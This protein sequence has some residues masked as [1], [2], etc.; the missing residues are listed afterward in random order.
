MNLVC[1]E[2]E[3][4]P[5]GTL[6]YADVERGQFIRF[7]RDKSEWMA[8]N[9]RTRTSI[10][11]HHN[12]V[13]LEDRGEFVQMSG[14]GQH[15]YS[16]KAFIWDPSDLS[17][18]SEDLCESGVSAETIVRAADCRLLFDSLDENAVLQKCRALI[19]L[20]KTGTANSVFT[21]FTAE[22]KRVMSEEFEMDFTDFIKKA[23]H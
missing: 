6:V 16:C 20:G 13:Y 10:Y 14:Y 1:G 11:L 15:C 23:V 17:V 5:D 22:Y 21:R 12:S 19:S 7:D 3:V 4:L 8:A 9:G 2:F 18:C